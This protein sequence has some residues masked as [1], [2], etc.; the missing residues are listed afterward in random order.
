MQ[1]WQ[2]QGEQRGARAEAQLRREGS[3]VLAQLN[4]LRQERH[5]LKHQCRELEA[6]VGRL[7]LKDDSADGG[8]ATAAGGGARAVAALASA[9]AAPA[10]LDTRRQQELPR[11]STS[12][13]G[14]AEAGR[15]LLARLNPAAAASPS[16]SGSSMFMRPSTAGAPSP[17]ATGGGRPGGRPGTSGGFGR[18]LSGAPNGSRG[19]RLQRG[20]PLATSH[21]SLQAQNAARRCTVLEGRV[22]ELSHENALAVSAAPCPP[23]LARRALPAQRSRSTSLQASHP[24]LRPAHTTPSRSALAAAQRREAEALRAQLREQEAVHKADMR[25]TQQT[26]P[27]QPLSAGGVVVQTGP[28]AFAGSPLGRAGPSGFGTLGATGEGIS[29]LAVDV[30]VV[31]SA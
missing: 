27:Q 9:S 14:G 11:P 10:L 4:E 29:A 3:V 7:R 22:D 16:G 13:A 6:E 8:V 21:T 19:G 15:A 12:N 2:A 1:R 23:R 30:N 17:G 5:D 26:A 31:G 28:E 20:L 18:G 25:R 24:F